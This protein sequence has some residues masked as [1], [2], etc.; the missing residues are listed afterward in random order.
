MGNDSDFSKWAL[1]KDIF[2]DLIDVFD[3]LLV[4]RYGVYYKLAFVVIRLILVV[5]SFFI[6]FWTK[7]HSHYKVVEIV[8]IW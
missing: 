8:K 2:V 1:A 5:W 6:S 3:L 4:E 7:T